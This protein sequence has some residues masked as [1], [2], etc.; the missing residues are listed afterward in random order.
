MDQEFMKCG[1][2]QNIWNMHVQCDNTIIT[3]VVGVE[4]KTAWNRQIQYIYVGCIYFFT[5][6]LLYKIQIARICPCEN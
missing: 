5:K 1:F 6:R 4:R 2:T 3:E